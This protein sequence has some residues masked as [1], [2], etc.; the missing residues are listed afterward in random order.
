MRRTVCRT[1]AC[2][3]QYTSVVISPSTKTRP[4]VVATSMAARA[5]G[6]RAMTSSRTASATASHSMSGC[7]SVTD[8]DVKRRRS[9]APISLPSRLR[10][11]PPGQGVGELLRRHRIDGDAHALQLEAGDLAIDIV[12]DVLHLWFE[13][14]EVGA[15]PFEVERV[16]CEA[17][18]HDEARMPL[19]G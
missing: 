3:S 4:V 18:V 11:G 12:G 2:T 5:P 8:S 19:G 9:S 17:H 10:P 6:S 13:Y 14:R 15:L 16:V 1:T 7:P